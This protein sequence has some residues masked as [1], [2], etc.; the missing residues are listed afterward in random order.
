MNVQENSGFQPQPQQNFSEKKPERMNSPYQKPERRPFTRE[1]D[2]RSSSQTFGLNRDPSGRRPRIKDSQRVNYNR[3]PVHRPDD[4]N[5]MEIH[6]QQRYTPPMEVRERQS[7]PER[8]PLWQSDESSRPFER[9]IT[10]EAHRKS[11]D[12]RET[13]SIA[14]VI[15]Q[16]KM[17]S[18]KR[19][20]R[21]CRNQ[22]IIIR[23]PSTAHAS[24]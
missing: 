17:C 4:G 11:Q 5:R 20:T 15:R 12:R 3:P 24:S 9:Q 13:L 16:T 23:M 6:R 22:E 1:F 19:K 8:T 18:L 7:V 14:R 21:N 2:K 10:T